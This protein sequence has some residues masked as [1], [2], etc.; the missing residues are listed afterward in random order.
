M[1]SKGDDNTHMGFN[2]IVA[3]TNYYHIQEERYQ[4]L[5]DYRDQFGAYRK[6]VSNWVLKS[7]HQKAEVLTWWKEWRSPTLHN[8]KEDAEKRAIEE[9]HAI[10]FMLG[11]NK[12]KYGKL[13][14]DMKNNVIHKK[15]P[16]RKTVAEACHILSKWK[17]NYRGKY[18]N[19]KS[20]S[21]DGIAFATIPEEKETNKNEILK[22]IKCFKCKKKGYY[23]N[24]CTEDLPGTT[25]NKG[26]SLLINKEDSSDKEVENEQYW[27]EEEDASV[28][29]EE[30]Q[31]DNQDKNDTAL[32]EN[33]E[34]DD[35]SYKDDGM[36]SDEDYVGLMFVQVVTC[37][38][39]DKAG[40]PES[41]ILLDSQST[42][43][44]FMNKK[45]LKNIHDV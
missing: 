37:N 41:W 26:K 29:S 39:N 5:Q 15:D 1:Y 16:F 9:H 10:L 4:S 2:H 28:T 22:D 42:I 33:K 13:V 27:T 18:N 14:E 11:A 44:V 19:G 6:C 32:D 23:S 3:I 25:E 21:Y 12:Y 36:I 43:D 40:I 30:Y 24:E 31:P 38:M 45:L 8:K 35:G 17:N 20:D 7:V 34:S